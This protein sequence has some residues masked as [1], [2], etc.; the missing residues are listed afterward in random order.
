MFHHSKQGSGHSTFF[1]IFKSCLVFEISG[2][3][4]FCL[5]ISFPF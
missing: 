4:L 1:S 2:F 5:L 3:A